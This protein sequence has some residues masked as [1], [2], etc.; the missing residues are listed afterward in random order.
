MVEVDVTAEPQLPESLA[1]LCSTLDDR[2]HLLAS[3]G[4]GILASHA[5]LATRDLFDLGASIT[6]GN[7]N[8][9]YRSGLSLEATSHPHLHPFLS[10]IF[11][12]PTISLRSSTRTKTA[13]PEP[14]APDP[15]EVLPYTPLSAL[16]TD[17]MD[18]EQVWAQLELRAEGV[19]RV[20][21]EMGNQ[22]AEEAD[23]DAGD[24]SETSSDDEGSDGSE[25]M[26]VEEFKRMIME[27]DGSE[28]IGSEGSESSGESGESDE[29]A[30]ALRGELHEEDDASLSEDADEED[31]VDDEEEEDE[32]EDEDEEEEADEADENAE[33]DEA[34][35]SDLE[36]D[37]LPAPDD[38]PS[39]AVEEDD[40]SALFGPGPSRPRKRPSHPTLD[41]EFFSIDDF[42]RHTEEA[43]AGRLST[44]RLRGE[45]DDDEGLEDVGSMMLG[46][47]EG[48]DGE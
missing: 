6:S 25:E 8:S 27:R 36:D 29:E 21:S 2:T 16:T 9:D 40:Q 23:E 10:S 3:T 30:F 43:E 19:G 15:K 14:E 12:P 28:G 42:N 46:G 34:I 41:D 48:D 20:I 32:E 39:S 35:G 18:V 44:G 7:S 11:E 47:G 13:A 17:G 1:Q 45:D 22:D 37:A 5:L 24:D 26:S 31:E 33:L 4:D 38:D